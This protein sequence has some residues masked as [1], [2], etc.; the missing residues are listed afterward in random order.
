MAKW[1]KRTLTVL[2]ILI[3]LIVAGYI[4]LFMGTTTKDA[5]SKVT[6][7]TA[8][9]KSLVVYFSRCGELAGD[10][11]AVSSATTNSNIDMDGSDT[12]AAAKMI[13]RLTGADLYQLHTKRYYRKAFF[14]TA[15]TA[16]IEENFNLRPALAAL[17]NNLGDYDKIYIGYPIWWFNAPMAVGTFLESYNWSGKTVIPFCTSQDNGIDVSMDFIKE[18]A[19]GAKI[20]E[21]HRIHGESLSDVA[22]WLKDIG[23][24]MQSNSENGNTQNTENAVNTT[25]TE[26]VTDTANKTEVAK[27][28]DTTDTKNTTKNVITGK[29]K[30][31]SKS[32]EN[33]TEG[34]EKYRGFLL[35]NVLH[36]EKEGDIHYNVYIPD[37]YDGSEVYALFMTLPGYQG[38]YFQGVGE[39]LR[40]ENIGFTAQKYNPKMIIVAPQLDDWGETSARQTVALTE[41]FLSA[42]NIDKTKVYAEGYSGGGETMSQVMGIKPELFTAYLQGSSQWDGEYDAVVESRT[43][44]YLV[45]G[46]SD[47][48]YGSGPSEEA[49]QNIHDLYKKEGLSEKQ[50]DKLLVLDVKDSSYFKKAGITNQHGQGGPLFFQDNEIMSWLFN[51]QK[52]Q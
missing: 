52:Q 10:V 45:V 6:K 30:V 37:S 39:N 8:G 47:E 38:L 22:S 17:P 35:D 20:L 27:K 44:V 36:S 16:W 5:N 28:E 34:T 3:L 2:I 50:I 25:D 24:Q 32:A 42:Y 29:T 48:Y 12:E 11:D 40:T 49:Y 46:E 13:Q 51:Q 18:N 26:S 33:I 9:T 7:G 21:G 14:G 1:K 15:A 41:Y 43:P 23:I 4:Y 31:F 19:K